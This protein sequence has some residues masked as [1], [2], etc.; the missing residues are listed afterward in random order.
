V[1]LGNPAL[2]LSLPGCGPFGEDMTYTTTA[3]QTASVSA[4]FF[5][6]KARDFVV[7]HWSF[8][9]FPVAHRAE[10]AREHSRTGDGFS[11]G[12]FRNLYPKQAPML[13]LLEFSYILHGC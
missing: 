1:N 3:G 9:I 13:D 2:C 6:P 12:L 7:P 4:I 5:A 10:S 8:S 11:S